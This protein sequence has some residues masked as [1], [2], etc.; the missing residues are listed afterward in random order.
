MSGWQGAYRGDRIWQGAILASCLVHFCL[1]VSGLLLLN[2]PLR[3]PQPSQAIQVSLLAPAPQVEKVTTILA[4]KVTVTPLFIPPPA[5]LE[6][7]PVIRKVQPV[8]SP[9]VKLPAQLPK[10]QVK[11]VLPAVVR[12]EVKPL[13]EIVLAKQPA[14]ERKSESSQFEPSPSS[15]ATIP[16]G[17]PANITTVV[18]MTASIVTT[19]ST[20]IAADEQMAIRERY[21]AQLRQQIERYKKYP[22]MARKGRQQGVVLV[23]FE[24][25]TQGELQSVMIKESC[26][27]RLLDQ[28]AL[29]AVEAAAPFPVIPQQLLLAEASFAVPL[30]FVLDH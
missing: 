4:E 22:L 5:V 29:R 14:L 18:A 17:A 27:K 1:V 23:E 30:R 15:V 3:L 13:T 19:E 6:Q 11:P 25:S 9:P 12:S 28:A 8:I 26:G 24:L 10:P 16:V 7:P 2:S 20:G 21:L